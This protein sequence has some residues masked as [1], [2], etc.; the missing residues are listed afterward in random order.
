VAISAIGPLPDLSSL[1]S[2]AKASPTG[3][4]AAAGATA[5]DDATSGG[6]SSVLGNAID[7]LNEAQSTASADEVQ[8]AAGQGTLANTMIAATEASL[9]TQVATSL[10]DKALTAYTSIANMSF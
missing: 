3:T 2:A 10:I 9:D 4:G 1:S 6:F 5:L 8:A 7:S